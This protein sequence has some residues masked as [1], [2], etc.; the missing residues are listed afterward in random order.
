M[1]LSAFFASMQP[2]S[3]SSP[4]RIQSVVQAQRLPMGSNYVE[5]PLPSPQFERIGPFLLL[6]HWQDLLPGNQSPFEIGVGPHPHRGFSPVTC[7]YAGSL[8][9]RDS[10]GN[11]QVIHAGGTQ[12]MD[13][14]SGIVHSERPD[15]A[16]AENGGMLEMIQFWV[17][18]PQE[19]KMKTASYQPLSQQETPTWEESGW[20][21]ALVQGSWNGI[22]SPISSNHALRVVNFK[23]EAANSVM[24]IPVPSEWSG[25][26]YVLD[27]C[28]LVD[29][30]R[31]EGRQMATIAPGPSTQIKIESLDACRVLMLI[32]APFNEPVI[33]HGPFVMSSYEE[34]QRAIMDYHDGKMGTL[35]EP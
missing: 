10:L 8:R 16:L 35:K 22:A 24:D 1:R 28:V 19:H 27:G 5:Q 15:D 6:H 2:S 11:D 26:V 12:W 34:I 17:N 14:G 31:T 20:R 23:T 3:Y 4:S 32:G 13:A 29:G 25:L 9:H 21:I 33:S 7:I 30:K 18:T